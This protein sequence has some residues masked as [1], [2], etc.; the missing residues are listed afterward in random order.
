MIPFADLKNYKHK[1]FQKLTSS[2]YSIS[3]RI[4]RISFRIR[5]F[6]SWIVYGVEDWDTA[7]LQ[8]P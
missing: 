2:S 5:G 6:N 4:S 7:S 3:T 8:L 1:Y